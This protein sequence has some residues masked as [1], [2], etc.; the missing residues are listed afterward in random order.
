MYNPAN[1]NECEVEKKKNPRGF[2][3]KVMIAVGIVASV[4]SIPQILKIFQEQTVEGISLT[5]QLL[6]L[7]SVLAWFFYGLYIK[8]R[9]LIVT[10]FVTAII[11]TIV[12]I[13]IFIYR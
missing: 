8:N 12:V 5:T 2:I 1:L 10:T 3:D 7:A 11:L 4:S 13:Q 6:A 9:P